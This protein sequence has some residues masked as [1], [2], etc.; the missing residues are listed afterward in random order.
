MSDTL[1][2]SKTEMMLRQ[3]SGYNGIILSWSASI[4]ADQSS[5]SSITLEVENLIALLEK[6]VHLRN[7]AKIKE[8][9]AQFPELIEVVPKAVAAAQKYFPNARLFMDVYFDPEIDDKYISVSV[10]L[11]EYN[12]SI[13]EKIE[14]AESEFLNDLVDKKGWIQLDT[15]YED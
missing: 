11:K 12:E 1:T 4:P 10:R 7:I 13:I 5:R 15:E 2:L 8:Y 3:L 14:K 9:L 6:W